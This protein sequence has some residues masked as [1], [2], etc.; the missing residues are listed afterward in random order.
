MTM[1]PYYQSI[2]TLIFCTAFPF[3]LGSKGREEIQWPQSLSQFNAHEYAWCIFARIERCPWQCHRCDQRISYNA[4]GLGI[5][6]LH[7]SS[8]LHYTCGA[9]STFGMATFAGEC[10]NSVANGTNTYSSESLIAVQIHIYLPSCSVRNEPDTNELNI[11]V[12]RS[13][14]FKSGYLKKLMVYQP[15]MSFMYG[16]WLVIVL[17]HRLTL[18][19]EIYPNI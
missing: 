15:F 19:V 2:H 6:F 1:N 5:S 18:D 7:G 11:W 13:M 4:H 10:I 9:D 8:A 14:P 12:N 16:N 3:Y 17:L